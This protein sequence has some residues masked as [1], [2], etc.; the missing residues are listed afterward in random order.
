MYHVIFA[1]AP[2]SSVPAVDAAHIIL[3]RYMAAFHLL[4][5]N[6]IF[7][8]CL[9]FPE[10]HFVITAII[11][12]IISGNSA[13]ITVAFHVN[14]LRVH[15]DQAG[16]V[17][18]TANASG[19]ISVVLIFH[20]RQ[21]ALD[22]VTPVVLNA[23]IRSVRRSCSL[24]AD[25]LHKPAVSAKNTAHIMSCSDCICSGIRSLHLYV[26]S[27]EI[28][29]RS[30]AAGHRNKK[31]DIITCGFIMQLKSV[32][33]NIGQVAQQGAYHARIVSASRPSYVSEA[34]ILHIRPQFI[35]PVYA[36]RIGLKNQVPNFNKI[37]L[38]IRVFKTVAHQV[39]SAVPL[40]KTFIIHTE[41][42]VRSLQP[43]DLQSG[44]QDHI[45][46]AGSIAYRLDSGKVQILHDPEILH[47]V[48]GQ[49][50]SALPAVRIRIDARHILICPR[51]RIR[52]LHPVNISVKGRIFFLTAV[53]FLEYQYGILLI[54]SC[55][56]DYP[57]AVQIPLRRH[58]KSQA[59]GMRRSIV[60][61]FG[62]L[63]IAACIPDKVH[64]LNGQFA[65]GSSVRSRKERFESVH[66][67]IRILPG[68][69]PETQRH[70]QLILVHFLLRIIRSGCSGR[71]H[72]RSVIFRKPLRRK[73][74]AL[75]FDGQ[76]I[77]QRQN[78][79]AVLIFQS[80]QISAL[81][82][83]IIKGLAQI[84]LIP[85]P[86]FPLHLL[87]GHNAFRVAAVRRT[88]S[89]GVELLQF[90][91]KAEGPL[92]AAAAH[93]VVIIRSAAEHFSQNQGILDRASIT[94]DASRITVGGGDIDLGPG[95]R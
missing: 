4:K 66:T 22:P 21:P 57:V 81:H 64:I 73:R 85:V 88:G 3:A 49:T 24:D 10:L 95:A 25:M 11:G 84:Q 55:I 50:H 93:P 83:G 27:S 46:V 56:P 58:L 69:I 8:C 77:L 47:A 35:D 48:A 52:I 5:I 90:R 18:I 45:I 63:N 72:G 41:A 31:S 44:S 12:I 32:N 6:R 60:F 34:Q 80:G 75:R 30:V 14:I 28:V 79:V 59:V 9:Q 42:L 51:H 39:L 17:Y 36:C 65:I 2:A 33:I 7:S 91:D 94:A 74:N 67:I 13:H 29:R 89:F 23:L 61:I 20:T 76:K 68:L 82:N 70:A 38:R 86:E 71:P 15:K 87:H 53:L 1:Q 19:I 54:L 92:C 37:Q 62:L 40:R 26:P 78:I 16:S 43:V